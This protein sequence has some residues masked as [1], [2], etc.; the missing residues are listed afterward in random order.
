[1]QTGMRLGEIL[2]LHWRHIDFEQKTLTIEGSITSTKE[3]GTFV[4]DTKTEAGERVIALSDFTCE[5]LRKVR[6]AQN[7]RNL[8]IQY[9]SD[10][11]VVFDSWPLKNAPDQYLQT[12]DASH[13]FGRAMSRL[14]KQKKITRRLRFHDLRH[15]HLS[16]LLLNGES[17]TTVA[18]RAGH[19]TAHTTLTT[20]AHAIAGEQKAM[21][22]RM[23]ENYLRAAKSL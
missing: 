9:R 14:L 23:D 17:V 10:D 2:A 16:L 11:A 3:R 6:T 22:E 12:K 4:K 13:T 7:E 19:K 18:Q 5:T 8:Q 20:Y 15:T 1:M 21:V